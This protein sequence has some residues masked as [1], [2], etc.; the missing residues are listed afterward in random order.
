MITY[1]IFQLR[2]VF[3]YVAINFVIILCYYS[4]MRMHMGSLYIKVIIY[5]HKIEKIILSL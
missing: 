5:M 2:I 4:N 3:S 1:D